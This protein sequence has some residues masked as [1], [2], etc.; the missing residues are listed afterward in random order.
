MAMGWNFVKGP[1]LAGL[2]LAHCASFAASADYYECPPSEASGGKV[3][4]SN[5]ISE[6]EAK[7]R[8]CTLHH[9]AAAWSTYSTDTSGTVFEYNP[10]R[11]AYDSPSQ[12][13]RTW[14]RTTYKTPQL[15]TFPN[16]K[17][18]RYVR[19]V[20]VVKVRC[21]SQ[22]GIPNGTLEQGETYFY[23]AKEANVWTDATFHNQMPPPPDSVGEALVQLLCTQ[24][25][26]AK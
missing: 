11:T 8:N 26:S 7:A 25:P 15:L 9:A 22:S 6:T 13:I 10:S 21:L 4:F 19:S 1:A 12:S 17:T 2:L 20:G 18:L 16:G 24:S 3:V 14:Q 5:S 23:D